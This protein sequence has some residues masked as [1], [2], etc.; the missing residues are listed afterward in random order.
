MGQTA[1]QLKERLTLLRI[2]LLQQLIW[3]RLLQLTLIRI[4]EPIPKLK[5]IQI[6]SLLQITITIRSLLGLHLKLYGVEF[7]SILGHNVVPSFLPE[8]THIDS[9]SDA[10]A[11]YSDSAVDGPI[12]SRALNRL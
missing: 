10:D 6:P 7:C 11:S 2:P 5:L 12:K 1:T 9:A 8:G 4:Q 3:I